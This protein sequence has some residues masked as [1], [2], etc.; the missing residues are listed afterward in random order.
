MSKNCAGK[1]WTK[2]SCTKMAKQYSA[3]Y[4]INTPPGPAHSAGAAPVSH[5]S[6]PH[7]QEFLRV[8]FSL[9]LS[10]IQNGR[11]QKG[12]ALSPI[13]LS[14]RSRVPSDR[15]AEIDEHGL[16]WAGAGL[17]TIFLTDKKCQI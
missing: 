16:G 17:P 3:N 2:V 11:N 15:E 9:P 6:L 13:S 4:V 12:G 5:F 8:S 14:L 10:R 1:L 7:L